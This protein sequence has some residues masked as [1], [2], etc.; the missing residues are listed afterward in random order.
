MVVG[1]NRKI[2]I[3]IFLRQEML[4]Y[5]TFIKTFNVKDVEVIFGPVLNLA[6]LTEKR[7]KRKSIQLVRVPKKI[8]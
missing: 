3:N 5:R 1:S 4:I 6:D 8:K 2:P 7:A